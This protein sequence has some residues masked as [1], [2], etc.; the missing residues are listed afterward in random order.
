MTFDASSLLHELRTPVNHVI[1]Y[2]DL[3]LEEGGLTPSTEASIAAAKALAQQVLAAAAGL[4]DADPAASAGAIN[5]L[6]VIVADLRR[7][8]GDV[9]HDQAHAADIDRIRTASE[10]LTQLVEALRLPGSVEAVERT[11]FPDDSSGPAGELPGTPMVLVVDDDEANRNVLSRRLVRLGYRV[12]EAEDG[13]AALRL[14]KSTPIDLVLLD[15]MMPELDGFGVLE[16][17]RADPALRDIPV[18][19]ISVLDDTESTVRCI[20]LGAEDY[21]PKP[22]DPVLLHARVGACLEKKR[23]RDA[24]RSLLATVT[25]Q[26]GELREWNA[27]LER[28]VDEKARE[29]ERLSLMERFVSPQLARAL[30]AGGAGMLDSH[31]REIT[32]LFCDLRGFT[33]FA[34]TAEPEDVMAVLAALHDAVGPLIFKYEGT[35]TQFTGDGMMVLFNDPIPCANPAISAIQLALEMRARTAELAIGWRRRGHDLGLGVG[36][37]IGY[38]TCGQIGFEGRFEYTAIGTVT[39][40]AARLCGEAKD[41]QV[42]IPAR[43]ATLLEH[44]VEVEHVGDLALKGIARPVAVYNVR[45]L[46]GHRAQR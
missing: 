9:A 45:G 17:R 36:I 18:V 4:L 33:S 10:R 26:A 30:E 23:L 21:L 1:G 3:L 11:E 46:A 34:E 41:G 35:L 27:E 40:I 39:N 24:E 32:V 2:A 14:L 31:R 15:I 16:E 38:A 42:L 13:R 12:V 28:R 5:T 37:A 25:R 43:I 8:I 20:E 29:V 6:D 22:F 44:E 19:M 7:C